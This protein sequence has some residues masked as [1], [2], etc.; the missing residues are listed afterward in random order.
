MTPTNLSQRCSSVQP[1]GSPKGFETWKHRKCSIKQTTLQVIPSQ[2]LPPTQQAL[3]CIY[4]WQQPPNGDFS[5]DWTRGGQH[6]SGELCNH[7]DE[8]VQVQQV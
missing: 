4:T 8:C 2:K 7:R 5:S 1:V 6:I 3:V